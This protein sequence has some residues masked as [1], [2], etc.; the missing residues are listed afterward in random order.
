MKK[1]WKMVRGKVNRR[2][3]E[4]KKGDW[5]KGK[6][7]R[8]NWSLSLNL[9]K[10]EQEAHCQELNRNIKLKDSNNNNSNIDKHVMIVIN[11]KTFK[12]FR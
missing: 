5:K 6:N 12:N 1:K 11:C 8:R 2:L 3:E 7:K 4:R 10:Q 9:Y